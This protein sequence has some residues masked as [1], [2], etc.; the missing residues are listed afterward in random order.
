[1][2]GRA[3]SN[4]RQSAF[5]GRRCRSAIGASISKTARSARSGRVMTSSMPIEDD[6]TGGGKQNFVLIGEKSTGRKGAAARQPAEGIR[7]PGRQAAEIVEGQNVAALP[8][9]TLFS[10]QTQSVAELTAAMPP[11]DGKVIIERICKPNSRAL[12]VLLGVLSVTPSMRTNSRL[13]LQ[14]C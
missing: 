2:C 4:S 13:P 7:Q 14:Q 9:C 10:A 1:M 5:S 6:R 8:G 12:R 11:D 3:S